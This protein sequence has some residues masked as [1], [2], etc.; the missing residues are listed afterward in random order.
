MR[1]E[2][3]EATEADAEYIAEHL[4]E[5]DRAE[6]E[7][8]GCGPRGATLESFHNSDECYCGLVE[9]RPALIFGVTQFLFSDAGLVWALGTD[10]C[11]RVPKVMV[12][13]GRLAVK[14]FSERYPVLENWCD[15]RY[16][17]ALN[18]LQRLGFEIGDPEPRGPKGALFRK[19]RYE[20]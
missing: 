7:A 8:S 10:D 4:R 18:W 11:G 16:E 1:T 3:R 19:L 6:I 13:A 20:R 14:L 15:A 12:K 5:A 17:K 9:G 2:I